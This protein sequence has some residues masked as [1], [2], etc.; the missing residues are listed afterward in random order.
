MSSEHGNA[1]PRPQG[2][3]RDGTDAANLLRAYVRAWPR[4]IGGSVDGE[5]LGFKFHTQ[6]QRNSDLADY[7]YP[8]TD[9]KR[10]KKG[11]AWS[12]QLESRLVF[13]EARRQVLS[14]D[15]GIPLDELREALPMSGEQRRQKERGQGA[16]ELGG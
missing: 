5:K 12:W 8:T 10:P 15:S 3:M 6:S 9:G 7:G 1:K 4:D 2:P 11:G 13:L 16:L 14:W